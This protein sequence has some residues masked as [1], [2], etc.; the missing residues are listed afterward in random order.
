[1]TPPVP[2]PDAGLNAAVAD[3]LRAEMARRRISVKELAQ[4]ADIPYGTLR[5]KI[6]AE[7]YIDVAELDQLAKALGVTSADIVR[8]AEKHA[9][10]VLVDELAERRGS[11]LEAY[12]DDE[13][14]PAARRPGRE[15]SLTEDPTE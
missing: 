15:P 7:R 10:R 3:E 1:M 8:A 4:L 9:G 6:S 12:E 11:A 2:D 14:K 5:R 13:V